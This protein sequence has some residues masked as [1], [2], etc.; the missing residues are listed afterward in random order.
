MH[1]VD[2][3]DNLVA[4]HPGRTWIH[5]VTPYSSV[6]DQGNNQWLIQFVQPYDPI[7]TPLP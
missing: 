7:D 6:T 5:I 2:T 4:L 1:F 3:R